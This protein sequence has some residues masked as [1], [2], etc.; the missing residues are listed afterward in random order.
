ML[1]T[2]YMMEEP[3]PSIVVCIHRFPCAF[4]DNSMQE[5]KFVGTTICYVSKE[6]NVVR[7]VDKN[8]PSILRT[9]PK[10]MHLRRRI[11]RVLTGVQQAWNRIW[12]LVYDAELDSENR[13]AVIRRIG[14]NTMY[15]RSAMRFSLTCER[16]Y[17][18]S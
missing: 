9:R 17:C 16:P 5:P 8:A 4:I 10:R 15:S 6:K 12:M 2:L 13:P 11:P 7:F 3:G 1:D 18:L 14:R